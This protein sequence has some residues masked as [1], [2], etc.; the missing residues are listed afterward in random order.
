LS[1]LEARAEVLK[2]ERLLEVDAGEF[3]FLA[4]L[5]SEDLRA[6][7]EQATERLFGASALGNVAGAARL[8]PAGVIATIAQRTFGPLL[9]ARAAGGVDPRTA[10]E[11]ARR[12]PPEFLA[13]VSIHLDPRRVAK[14]IAGV[15]VDLVPG[16]ARILGERREYVTMGRFLAFVSDAAIGAAMGVLDDEALVRTA[17]VLEHKDRLDHA[18]G[19]LPPERLP[20]VLRF[21]AAHDLWPEALD[22]LDQLSDARRG[23]I[24]DVVAAEAQD[25]LDSLVAAVHQS[26]LWDV[27]LPLVQTMQPISRERLAHVSTFHEPAVLRGIVVAAASAPG[28]WADLVPLLGVL[29]ADV[30]GYLPQIIADLDLALIDRVVAEAAKSP[31]TLVPLIDI[32]SRIQG[33]GR[34]AVIDLIDGADEALARP[35]VIH[36]GD[37]PQAGALLRSLPEDVHDAVT[38]A[39]CRLGLGDLLLQI[40]GGSETSSVV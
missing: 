28:L 37:L 30:Q 17:F 8:L 6:L 27:M 5:P 34:T 13:D 26:G 40:E 18:I 14:I 2:L 21:A 1:E 24:A 15:P 23:P 31:E 32:A 39:A 22:L 25:I 20:G 11:V 9:C 4:E 19:L 29:P 35:L 12:L 38:R 3:A 33:P 7:R 16:V 10:I 36:F